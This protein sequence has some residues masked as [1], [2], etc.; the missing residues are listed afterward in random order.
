MAS[1]TH[2]GVSVYKMH[3]VEALQAWKYRLTVYD[4]T[5]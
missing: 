3:T 2:I 4:I 1:Y 5:Q